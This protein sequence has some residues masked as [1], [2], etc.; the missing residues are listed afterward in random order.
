MKETGLYTIKQVSDLTHLPSSTLRFWEKEFPDLIAP[1]RT[2]G[3]QRRYPRTVI[4]VLHR[5]K[6][7]REEGL[8]L[9][10]IKKNL[11]DGEASS[12]AE[13]I[14]LLA[15]RVAEAVKVELYNFFKTEKRSG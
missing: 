7:M 8:T 10:V 6:K 2:H 14:D 4:D 13:R 5:I 11:L 1:L 12:D 9:P 3:G 15:H